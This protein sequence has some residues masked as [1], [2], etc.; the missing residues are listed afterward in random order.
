MCENNNFELK[1]GGVYWVRDHFFNENDEQENAESYHPYLVVSSDWNN[2]GASSNVTVA[3]L[4]TNLSTMTM[5]T[6]VLLNGY[7]TLKPSLVKAESLQTIP[8]SYI[9][10]KICSL[11]K[12]DMLNVD[13]CLAIVLSLP[14]EEGE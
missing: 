10:D 5:H 2:V 9:G 4:S 6:H 7:K 13:R 3:M 11:R 8:K 1:R 12:G 14:V